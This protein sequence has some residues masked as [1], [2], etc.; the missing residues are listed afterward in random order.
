MGVLKAE[1][2]TKLSIDLEPEEMK[3]LVEEGRK[4]DFDITKIK[5]EPVK[6]DL[7]NLNIPPFLIPL[8]KAKISKKF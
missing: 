1:S 3:K 2:L 8:I 4:L 6:F 7:K 5:D